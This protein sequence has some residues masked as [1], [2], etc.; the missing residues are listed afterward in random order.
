MKKAKVYGTRYSQA[1][2]H[3]STNRARRC[4][5]SVIGREPVLS[6]WY[7]R[8]RHARAASASDETRSIELTC[9]DF[10]IGSGQGGNL[11]CHIYRL[12]VANA[13]S[14][15]RRSGGPSTSGQLA[16]DEYIYIAYKI[17]SGVEFWHGPTFDQVGCG[18]PN[19]GDEPI[20]LNGH[21]RWKGERVDERANRAIDA[22]CMLH[23]GVVE[24]ASIIDADVA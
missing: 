21:R 5:T 8:R 14:S 18:A 16:Y 9:D 6:T 11:N 2:T 15:K 19:R 17:F 7:G 10:L 23:I 13:R 24:R 20:E 4:L 1:V 12:E 3:P 22:D